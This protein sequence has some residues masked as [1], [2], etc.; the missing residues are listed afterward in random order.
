MATNTF[1]VEEMRSYRLSHPWQFVKAQAIHSISFHPLP[2]SKRFCLVAAQCLPSF[3]TQDK[4]VK[5]M[6]VILDKLKDNP[7][8]GY[9]ICTTGIGQ[10]CTHLGAL[11]FILAELTADGIQHLEDGPA[12]TEI[13][14]K[15]TESKGAR[16][17]SVRTKDDFHESE[18][19]VEGSKKKVRPT[20]SVYKQLIP[21]LPA[22]VQYE[23]AV[24]FQQELRFAADAM[25][26]VPPVL[27]VL[28]AT[29]Y[30]PSNVLH[31]GTTV[32]PHLQY[33]GKVGECD[34]L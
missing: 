13:L 2:E 33:T 8:A 1:S 31:S 26:S 12:C 27:H 29:R 10:A 14:C 32:T 18:I 9:C 28:D 19:N 21:S 24:R 34:D 20:P 3:T 30:N 22:A 5:W 6:H 15:W 16:V 17:E 7:V 25:D 11:L 23:R 4:D